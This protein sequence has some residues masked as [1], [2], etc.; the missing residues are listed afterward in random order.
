MTGISGVI[1]T[2]GRS[3]IWIH[4]GDP[5]SS[6]SSTYPLR[7]TYGCVRITNAHQNTMVTKIT[8]LTSSTGYHDT[9]GKISIVEQ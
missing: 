2:S 4:G 6:G 9:T 7:P 3:G 8:S 5:A 1:K